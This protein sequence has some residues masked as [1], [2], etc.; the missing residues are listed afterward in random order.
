MESREG[1]NHILQCRTI[2]QEDR[3]SPGQPTPSN[4]L[5]SRAAMKSTKARKSP[6]NHCNFSTAAEHKTPRP[7]GWHKWQKG[8]K[9]VRVWRK[10]GTSHKPSSVLQSAQRYSDSTKGEY[11]SGACKSATATITSRVVPPG[12]RKVTEIFSPVNLLPKP[13]FKEF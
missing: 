13:K 4:Q 5:E 1:Q 9:Q 12:L 3:S 8:E 2:T 7:A 10:E 6:E 11:E